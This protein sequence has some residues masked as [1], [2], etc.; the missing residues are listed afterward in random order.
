MAELRPA[1]RALY[2]HACTETGQIPGK[3]N[4]MQE[5]DITLLAMIAFL[6]VQSSTPI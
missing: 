5:L 1:R 3:E 2:I 4:L 6:A